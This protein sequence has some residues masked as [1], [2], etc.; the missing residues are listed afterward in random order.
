MRV[1]NE[2]ELP[3]NRLLILTT[4]PCRQAVGISNTVW[5]LIICVIPLVPIILKLLFVP[6]KTIN[7]SQE[8]VTT[9]KCAKIDVK[10]C[11]LEYI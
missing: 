10:R 4:A 5:F 7:I 9:I 2:Y 8:R 11:R 6:I 1:R 3:I